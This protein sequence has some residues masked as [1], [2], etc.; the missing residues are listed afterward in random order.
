MNSFDCRYYDSSGN[1]VGQLK[2]AFPSSCGAA[3]ASGTADLTISGTVFIDGNLS[4]S[5]CDYAVY[6]GRGTIY[7]NGTVNFANGAKVCAKPISG[8]PCNGNYDQ[9]QNLLEL[10]ALNAGNQA[11]GFTMS[12]GT[13]YE[14]VAFTNGVFNEGNGAVLNGP[15]I[16]DRATMSGNAQLRTTVNPPSGSPGA[17]TTTTTTTQG[18]DQVSWSGVA[19]SW[20][21]LK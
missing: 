17:A 6:Q 5:G 19:G 8:S 9:S 2:W 4:F 14:G 21:Q 11:S 20:Q 10:V 1:L 13:T 12:G 18:P 16:A 3:P 15:V 7:V